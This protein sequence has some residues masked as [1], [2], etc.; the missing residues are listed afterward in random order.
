MMIK[1]PDYDPTKNLNFLK[2]GPTS[3]TRQKRFNKSTN[4]YDYLRV[5]DFQQSAPDAR[6]YIDIPKIEDRKTAFESRLVTIRERAK[7]LASAMR[8]TL[9][10]PKFNKKMEP[11]LTPGGNIDTRD[12]L[13]S[14]ITKGE[15]EL[16][17][18][19][20]QYLSRMSDLELSGTKE[21]A[22][23][24]EILGGAVVTPEGL[25]RTP[26]SL[27]TPSGPTPSGPTPSGPTPTEGLSETVEGEDD[28]K[29]NPEEGITV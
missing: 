18:A 9:P 17:R 11:I 8:K 22:L 23:M 21:Y 12:Y 6:G 3:L 7:V 27:V 1:R 19:A 29:K 24:M 26:P 16:K 20:L 14:E 10:L 13:F 15:P 25:V 28:E 2:T 5:S 4:F